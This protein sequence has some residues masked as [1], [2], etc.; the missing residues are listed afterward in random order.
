MKHL[1]EFE[2]LFDKSINSRDDLNIDYSK[3]SNIMK[4]KI[5]HAKD[6]IF[7]SKNYTTD[8]EFIIDKKELISYIHQAIKNFGKFESFFGQYRYKDI[9]GGFSTFFYSYD[10]LINRY[11]F[12][13]K[14]ITHELIEFLSY[15]Y[16]ELSE[17]YP[18]YISKH[19]ESK[20]LYDEQDKLIQ[21]IKVR[22]NELEESTEKYNL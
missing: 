9:T 4:R 22:Y 6:Y 3:V 18:G 19:D 5:K 12:Y 1:K 11:G 13:P 21:K 10:D 2:N 15:T 8:K 7:K 20:R 17:C 14:N 16:Y